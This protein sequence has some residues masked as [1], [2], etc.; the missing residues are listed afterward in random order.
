[1][2]YDLDP[3]REVNVTVIRVWGLGR[4]GTT[5]TLSVIVNIKIATELDEIT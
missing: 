3:S 2:F 5:V 1:M 4:D